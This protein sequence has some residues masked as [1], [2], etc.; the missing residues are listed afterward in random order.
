MLVQGADRHLA[1]IH[2]G[3]P[4]FGE[5][6]RDIVDTRVVVGVESAQR[7]HVS[8]LIELL[9]MRDKRLNQRDT[10]RPTDIATDVEQGGGL[11]G[12]P[13]RKADKCSVCER[14]EEEWDRQRLPDARHRGVVKRHLRAQVRHVPERECFHDE[15]ATNEE[16]R[17]H[18]VGQHAGERHRDERGDPSGGQCHAGAAGRVAQHLL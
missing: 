12:Q 2:H 13:L 15:R 11:I 14:N 5:S 3:L 4:L 17:L 9:A 7:L 10:D 6:A 1:C 18:F 8:R 16:A